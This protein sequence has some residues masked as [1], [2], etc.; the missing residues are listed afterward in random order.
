MP[1][2]KKLKNLREKLE[3]A[4]TQTEVAHDLKIS[5][6]KLSHLERGDSGPSSLD[7][8]ALCLYYHV[9]ADYLLDLPKNLPYPDE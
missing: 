8:T 5:Q 9:S 3:P 1:L 6:R 2:G 7:L 4:K